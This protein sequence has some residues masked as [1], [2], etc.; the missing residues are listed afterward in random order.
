MFFRKLSLGAPEKFWGQ[1]WMERKLPG[2]SFRKSGYTWQGCPIFKNFGKCCAILYWKLPKMQTRLFGW[3]E[4]TQSYQA[5]WSDPFG[6]DWKF[7]YCLA[8]KKWKREFFDMEQQVSIGSDRPVKENHLW[9]WTTFTTGSPMNSKQ[10]WAACALTR[11]FPHGRKRSI[12]FSTEISKTFNKM[13]RT[14]RVDQKKRGTGNSY[15]RKWILQLRLWE[16]PL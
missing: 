11:K 3:M 8:K 5:N 1:S 15:Y 13:E 7:D 14:L 10:S 6:F 4:S 16:V 9:K 2:K 12:Y